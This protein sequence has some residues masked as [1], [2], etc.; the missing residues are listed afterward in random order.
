MHPGAGMQVCLLLILFSSSLT[1]SSLN[2]SSTSRTSTS[3]FPLSIPRPLLPYFQ[4][5]SKANKRQPRHEL[6]TQEESAK[7]SDFGVDFDN[8]VAANFTEA[9][10]KMENLQAPLAVRWKCRNATRKI[11]NDKKTTIQQY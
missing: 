5:V 7:K 9:G 11:Q 6:T 8:R 1:S 4:S 2:S 3:H 10:L